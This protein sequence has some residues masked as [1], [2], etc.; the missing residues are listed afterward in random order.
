MEDT[1]KPEDRL[2]IYMA[3]VETSRK[4]V[5]VMD[6]KAG[7]LSGL[8]ALLLG[9]IWTGAKLMEGGD[10]AKIGLVVPSNAGVTLGNDA[11]KLTSTVLYTDLADSTKLVDAYDPRFAAEICKA[12]LH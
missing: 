2:K 7:F 1:V 9:Y 10:W 3:M 12:F 8:N 5:S 4:W 11:V 6:T